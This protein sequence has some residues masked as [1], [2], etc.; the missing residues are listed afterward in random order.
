[1]LLNGEDITGRKPS[2]IVRLGLARTFQNAS[3]YPD[4][5]VYE[6]IL[7][8]ALWKLKTGLLSGLLPL[9]GGYAGRYAQERQLVD[10]IIE[11]LGLGAIGDVMA[12]ELSYGLQ[13]K[14]GVAIGLA[15]S[16]KIL[17]MD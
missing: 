12:K 2:S 7:R 14:V 15:T 16:P 17:L 4:E 10:D 3:L 6:N 8:G 13:K 5:S 9:S 11:T 1:I